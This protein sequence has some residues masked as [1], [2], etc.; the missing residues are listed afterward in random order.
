M[1]RWGLIGLS[2]LTLWAQAPEWTVAERWL[3]PSGDTLVR[4]RR[5]GEWWIGVGIGTVG[6]GYLGRLNLPRVPDAPHRG[7]LEFRR[8]LGA[9]TGFWI[10][11]EWNPPGERW[12]ASLLLLPWEVW[13]GSAQFE[14]VASGVRQQYELELQVRSL[15]LSASARYAPGWWRGTFWEGLHFIVG[16]DARFLWSA[17]ERVRQSLQNVERIEEWRLFDEQPLPLWLGVHVGVGLDIFVALFGENLRN[18]VTPVVLF[19]T[20]LPL[21][22]TWGSTWTPVAIRAGVSFKLG[23]ER[24]Q[25]RVLPLDTAVPFIAARVPVEPG[26]E[27]PGSTPEEELEG[28]FLPG[29]ERPSVEPAPE[30]APPRPA[31]PV[32]IVPNRV[33]RFSY[34]SP[35]ATGL[36][37][38]LQRYLD[39]LVDYLRARPQAEVRIVGHTEEF[40]GSLEETQRISEQ[41][42]QQVVEYLARRGIS[43]SRLLASGVGAR[44]PIADNRTP[45]GRLR[46]RRVEIIVVE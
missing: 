19:Q 11:G 29:P 36:T 4:E 45:E 15:L 5:P 39:A 6:I 12:G 26:V 10:Q 43:R 27:L 21:Q 46:N 32:T 35:T 7:L 34:P 40:G 18:Y 3:L 23:W 8:G 13:R 22:R 30:A 38:E 25:E 44:Q 24:I 33:Q 37:A 2:V 20:G 14:P 1:W 31:Q 17:R 41:R 9:G 28:E 16:T 42:A